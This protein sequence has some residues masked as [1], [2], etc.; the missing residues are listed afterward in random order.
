MTIRTVAAS[1]P[2]RVTPAPTTSVL[3]IAGLDELVAVVLQLGHGLLAEVAGG[4]PP[5]LLD[6]VVERD[7]VERGQVHD[8]GAGRLQGLDVVLGADR[9]GL[10][11]GEPQEG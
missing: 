11:P 7:V 10:G 5:D 4:H 3:T 8:P 9:G 6:V 1:L 2:A